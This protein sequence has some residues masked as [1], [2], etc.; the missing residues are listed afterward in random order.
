MV[1][2]NLRGYIFGGA[3]ECLIP[4]LLLRPP[5]T[6]QSLIALRSGCL[7]VSGAV[8]PSAPTSFF[9]RSLPQGSS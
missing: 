7:R 6:F 2:V 5:T 1:R 9:C 4:S 8:A 3:A